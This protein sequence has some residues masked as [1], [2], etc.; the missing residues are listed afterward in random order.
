LL[1]A[2]QA[3][4]IELAELAARRQ[5]LEQHGRALRTRLEELRQ[6]RMARDQQ[7]RLLVGQLS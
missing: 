2:Y 3:G 1:D 6:Q 5:R 7:L 4:V